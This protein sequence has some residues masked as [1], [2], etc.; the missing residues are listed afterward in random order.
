M[1]PYI[2]IRPGYMVTYSQPANGWERSEKQ[3]LTLNNLS[4]N[5]TKGIISKKAKKSI[6]NA[7]DWLLWLTSEKKFFSHKHKKEFW[8]KLNFVT[9]TLPSKQIHTDNEIKKKILN[10]F[11]TE[12]RRKWGVVHY[13]WRAEAQKNGNIHFHI[14]FDKFLPWK[15]LKDCWNNCTNVLGYVNRFKEKHGNKNP[16]STDVHSIR[17]IKNISAYLAK[18][19]TKNS[20]NRTIGGN[21]W[22]LSTS[23]SKIK[24][25]TTVM[26][27]Q[28]FAELD[29][30]EKKHPKSFINKDYFTC[31]YLDVKKWAN[32]IKGK[33]WKIFH[34]F[35]TEIKGS[36]PDYIPFGSTNPN[37]TKSNENENNIL[38]LDFLTGNMVEEQIVPF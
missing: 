21:L 34:D 33:L 37:G 23:L 13:L 15:E 1:I 28:C 19:C 14:V 30:I 20:D 29:V 36:P 2:A 6:S 31:I 10:Y 5:D 25:A 22:G 7:I 12:A 27:S 3:Q 16:N 4:N 35:V 26:D 8:F 18:Y 32:L 38:V 9:L 17:K 24:N 11:L